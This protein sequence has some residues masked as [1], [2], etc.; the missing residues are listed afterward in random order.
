LGK[1][2]HCDERGGRDPSALNALEVTPAAPGDSEMLTRFFAGN[3]APSS[4]RS[5]DPFE[6]TAERAQLIVS[7]SSRDR[8]Y[9]ARLDSELVA[10][11]ML[12]GFGEG[13]AIP[14]F[15]IL[16]DRR[17][18]GR[19]IGRRVTVWTLEAARAQRCPA[20]RLTVYASNSTAVALYRSLGFV[21]RSR[22]AV[23]R[24]GSHDEKIVMQLDWRAGR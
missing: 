8:F 16:V 22:A 15:G 11:S 10:M 1:S 21:E 19:G 18:R 14:S 23:E 13:Y 3:R 9:L 4:S 20:V 5:F 7:G 17:H 2:S 6:L 24:H 12:R